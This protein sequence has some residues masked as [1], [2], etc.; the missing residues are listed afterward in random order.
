MTRNAMAAGICAVLAA[1]SQVQPPDPWEESGPPLSL[2][3]ACSDIEIDLVIPVARGH[4]AEAVALL[5]HA[6]AAP[7]DEAYAGKLAG[8]EGQ[9]LTGSKLV[10]DALERLNRERERVLA[11]R[12]GS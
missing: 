7:I 3:A 9:M 4:R 1:C 10:A 2:S 6:K 8:A 11:T 12:T 5:E